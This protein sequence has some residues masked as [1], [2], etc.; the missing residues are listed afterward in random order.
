M[1]LAVVTVINSRTS[2]RQ[3]IVHLSTSA[4]A[5]IVQYIKLK[6]FSTNTQFTTDVTSKLLTVARTNEFH[7]RPDSKPNE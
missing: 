3:I 5:L 4:S 6:S 7:K 1:T 2:T